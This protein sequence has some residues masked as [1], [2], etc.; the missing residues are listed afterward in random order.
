MFHRTATSMP[1][2]GFPSLAQD[3]SQI[4]SKISYLSVKLVELCIVLYH[5]QNMATSVGKL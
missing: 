3:C 5:L 4:E 1:I 2:Q